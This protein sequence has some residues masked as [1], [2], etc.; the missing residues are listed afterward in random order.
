MSLPQHVRDRLIVR[1]VSVISNDSHYENPADKAF[2]ILETVTD[3]LR[4]RNTDTEIHWL[5]EFAKRSS[6]VA[7]HW[8]NGHKIAAIKEIRQATGCGLV[9]AKKAYEKAYPEDS[10]IAQLREKLTGEPDPYPDEPF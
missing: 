8:T 4:E 6:V 5:V 2:V 9:D 7:K 10:A 3:T 1:L